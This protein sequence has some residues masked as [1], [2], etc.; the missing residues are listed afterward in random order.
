MLLLRFCVF[1]FVFERC[2]FCFF[3]SHS[4]TFLQIYFYWSSRLRSSHF[5]FIECL[6]TGREKANA[7]RYRFF[8]FILLRF[9]MVTTTFNFFICRSCSYFT[10][11]RS[12]LSFFCEWI[13]LCVCVFFCVR[14]FSIWD[15]AYFVPIKVSLYNWRSI[16]NPFQLPVSKLR[17]GTQKFYISLSMR[18]YFHL[19]CRL[20]SLLGVHWS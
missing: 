19:N 10:R 18:H 20:Q 4:C 7:G 11:T 13:E 9:R 6:L 14:W 3:A 2:V 16:S 8:F 15:S 1:V 12:F 17:K 5:S